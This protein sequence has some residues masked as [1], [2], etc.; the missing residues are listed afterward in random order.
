MV[1]IDV[2]WQETESQQPPEVRRLVQGLVE[3]LHQAPPRPASEERPEDVI[4]DL[5]VD[6]FRC[7]VTRMAPE[8]GEPVSPGFPL[9]PREMEIARMVAKGYPNK[10]IAA[11]LEISSWT[12][13]THLRRMFAKLSV[14]SR[15]AMVARLLEKREAPQVSSAAV[16]A[17]PREPAARTPLRAG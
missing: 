10:T 8:T 6:G 2:P 17:P 13:S 4:L 1:R 11:V 3:E 7:V 9:S 14:S 15:A 12:V 16:P 5:V